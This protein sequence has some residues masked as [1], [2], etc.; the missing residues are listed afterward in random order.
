[1]RAGWDTDCT[2]ATVGSILGVKF[3][4]GA[5][6]NKWVGVLNDRLL[7]AVRNE[8]DNKISDLAARTVKVAKVI[9][10]AKDEVDEKVAKATLTGTAGGIWELETGWGNQRV[11]FSAG[12]MQFVGDEFGPYDLVS[13]SYSHPELKFSY[14]IDKGGWDFEVDFEGTVSGETIEGA[15]YPGDVPVRGRRITKE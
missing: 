7:S 8:N 11:D 6:P 3:G 12:T 2:G 10:A 14:C 1:V 5:L 4:A 9:A 15:F 13:S